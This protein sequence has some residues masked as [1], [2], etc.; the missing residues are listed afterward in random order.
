MFS[1]TFREKIQ[2]KK[3]ISYPEG[4]ESNNKWKE[5]TV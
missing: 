1:I 5:S 3:V 4:I 2:K